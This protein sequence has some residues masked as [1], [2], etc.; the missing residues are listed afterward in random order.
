MCHAAPTSVFCTAVDI[1]SAGATGHLKVVDGFSSRKSTATSPG[2]TPV[3]GTGVQLVSGMPAMGM[4]PNVVASYIVPERPTVMV[5]G[6]PQLFARN[7][8]KH[9]A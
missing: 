9:G 3:A 1:D 4:R 7:T 6:V 2:G 8:A 5:I